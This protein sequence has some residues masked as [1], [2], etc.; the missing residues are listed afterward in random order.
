[1]A[2]SNPWQQFSKP[3]LLL[4]M[5]VN[6]TSS[7]FLGFAAHLNLPLSSV[8]PSEYYFNQQTDFKRE[9]NIRL[10]RQDLKL[11]TWTTPFPGSYFDNHVPGIT[12]AMPSG[13]EI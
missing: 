5:N 1:M 2:K 10:C 3:S 9:T 13:T 12:T 7:K 4:E 8:G 11:I 6:L